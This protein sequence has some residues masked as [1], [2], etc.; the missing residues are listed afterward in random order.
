[1]FNCA[2]NFSDEVHGYSGCDAD[3]H[4]RPAKGQFLVLKSKR[5][6]LMLKTC[7]VQTPS[8]ETAGLY[9][10]ETVYGGHLVV[11][12]TREVQDSKHDRSCDDEVLE[13]LR[14]HARR[15]IKGFDDL[16]LET[17]TSFSGAM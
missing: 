6:Q 2:G 9:L 8:L 7:V 15:M 13:S 3:F 17:C 11:G 1:M 10:F 14:R 4:I 5:G 12:P 16:G